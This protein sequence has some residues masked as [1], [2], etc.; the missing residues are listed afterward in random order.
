MQAWSP[1]QSMEWVWQRWKMSGRVC[2]RPPTQWLVRC[3][4]VCSVHLCASIQTCTHLYVHIYVNTVC[5]VLLFHYPD[6]WI[7]LKFKIKSNNIFICMVVHHRQ[8]W[9]EHYTFRL[10]IHSSHSSLWNIWRTPLG[11]FLQ[12]WHKC[13]LRVMDE[14][15]RFLWSKVKDQSHCDLMSIPFILQMQYYRKALKEFLEIWHKFPLGLQ[16]EMI[17]FWWSNVNVTVTSST[18]HQKCMEGITLRLAQMSTWTSA[19]NLTMLKH[20]FTT[21]PVLYD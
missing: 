11:N 20:H 5:T 9:Q 12:I 10:F 21:S 17:R 18:L 7:Y 19:Y 8:P 6:L 4:H 2:L 14:L 3:F 1:A 13:T 15:V 16:T